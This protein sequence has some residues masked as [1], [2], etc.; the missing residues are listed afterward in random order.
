MT[1]RINS[2]QTLG[3]VDG[4]GVRFVLFMQG[5]PL[6]CGFCHNPDTWDF[7]G[8][9]EVTPDEILKKILRYREYFGEDGG[10]TI[11]GGEP[12]AQAE[13]VRELF[14]LCKENGINTALD[15]SGCIWNE[16]VEKLLDVTDICLLD[17]KMTDNES[18]KK[19]IGCEMST[20][21]FFLDRLQE[22]NIRTWLRQVIV[23]GIND[24]QESVGRLYDI[25]DSHPCV[26]K[27]EL[28]KFRKICSSKYDN[29]NIAFPFGNIPETTDDQIKSLKRI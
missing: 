16:N 11:S 20:V 3:T 17:I 13:F 15:T 10:I 21:E 5:C 9:E 8:G 26:E 29:L 1:G 6:R 23:T 2:I 12:L 25:A 14:S 22:K 27:T 19:H 24:T 18:Y 7:S 4:P 28:L